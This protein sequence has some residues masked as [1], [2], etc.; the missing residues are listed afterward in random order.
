MEKEKAK[1]RENKCGR[2]NKCIIIIIIAR[3]PL[4]LVCWRLGVEY[5]AAKWAHFLL[6]GGFLIGVLVVVVREL[7]AQNL[8]WED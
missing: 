4:L 6:S 3:L 8:D 1:A 5:A 2:Q 7:G